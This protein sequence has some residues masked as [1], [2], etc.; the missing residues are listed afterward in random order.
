MPDALGKSI[1]DILV[2]QG[3]I[4]KAQL[5]E[6]QAN[7]QSEGGRLEEAL[8][9]TGI[10]TSSEVTRA[11][12]RHYRRDVVDLSQVQIAPAL[13][14]LIPQAIAKRQNIV[15]IAREDG[16]ILVA[17]AE[18]LDFNTLD[19]LR[20]L[21]GA[22]IDYVFADRESLQEA[23]NRCYGNVEESVDTL[24][25]EFTDSDITRVD[26]TSGVFTSQT[27]EEGDDAPIVRL[28]HMVITDAI[29]QRA[30]DIHIE[31]LENRLRVR[32]RID[33][34]CHEV[35]NPPKRLQG[36]I[37]SRV[38]IMASMNIAEKRL[39]QDGRIQM[40]VAGRDI[41]FRVSAL[42]SSHGES[43]VM[44][45]LDRESVLMNIEQ[46]GFDPSD[47]ERFRRIIRRPNGIFLVTGPTG[48]GKTTT[49]YG[50]LN[51]LNRPDTKIIT[52]EDPV[53]YTLTGINQV[54]VKTQ[55]GMTFSRILRSVLRQ[56]PNVILVGEIR[57]RETAEIAIQAALTGHLVFSTLHTNDAPSAITRLIDIGVK[58]FLCAS[59]VMAVMAQR[60]IRKT[61]RECREPYD[62]GRATLKAAG[63]TDEQIDS[64]TF[65]RG[66]GCRAC[67][68]TGF[69]GQLGIFELMEMNSTL[70][71]LAFNCAPRSELTAAAQQGGMVTLRRDGLRKVLAGISTVEEILR[72]TTRG[73]EES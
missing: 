39:P 67:S 5:E 36:A 18:P 70:R 54:E 21:L 52:A 38:K 40:R 64:T 68:N 4:T 51:E 30:S 8:L 48:S 14:E 10:V 72:I 32:Y 24:L 34:V 22:D 46:L 49:L 11:W 15:P 65:Y 31:P 26:K 9:R 33:G 44:R 35:Q 47:H 43:I 28:V 37:L 53:E 62:P 19:N 66:V 61:C 69:R 73:D 42:P 12:A 60:L 7:Q 71:E 27:T 63:L 6:A 25:S 2:E 41:D 1:G 20:F 13:L 23:V 57:D 50:A 29:A 56:A 55:I 59:A 17:S 3:V 45:I 16:R 58:P